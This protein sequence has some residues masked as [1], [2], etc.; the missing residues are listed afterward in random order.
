MTP[1]YEYAD[2]N[3]EFD[4]IKSLPSKTIGDF[5]KFIYLKKTLRSSNPLFNISSVGPLAKKITLN[6][7]RKILDITLLGIIYIKLI[8]I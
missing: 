8:P 4:I 5:A 7:T 3:R 6:S 2:K 1:F